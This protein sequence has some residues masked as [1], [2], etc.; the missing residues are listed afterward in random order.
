MLDIIL[1]ILDIVFGGRRTSLAE[2][3]LG[4]TDTLTEDEIGSAAEA[5]AEA[6]AEMGFDF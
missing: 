1:D 5:A 2:D 4:G 3:L 6:A